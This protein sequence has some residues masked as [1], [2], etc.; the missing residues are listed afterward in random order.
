LKFTYAQYLQFAAQFSADELKARERYQ[1]AFWTQKPK[2]T[3]II[4]AFD[5]PKGPE[6]HYG[7]LAN[8][9]R[10]FAHANSK[11]RARLLMNVGAKDRESIPICLLVSA[12]FIKAGTQV[13]YDY[14][15]QYFKAGGDDL[16][17]G[18]VKYCVCAKCKDNRA[19]KEF[20]KLQK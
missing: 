6:V 17:W 14:G 18:K 1:I 16:A 10:D 7:R 20:R 13:L 9:A 4:D 11:T 5:E 2:Q 3:Y 12:S 8:H 15:L 19:L